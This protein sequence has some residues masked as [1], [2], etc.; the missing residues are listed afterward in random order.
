MVP[1]VWQMCSDGL[2][3]SLVD[4]IKNLETPYHSFSLVLYG[5]Y[6]SYVI[7]GNSSQDECQ[8]DGTEGCQPCVLMIIH[9]CRMWVARD[10]LRGAKL[11]TTAN[12]PRM[13][14]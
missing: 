5:F 13:E 2:T 8:V 4:V 3:L 14:L 11:L 10:G 7:N 1:V 6:H 9:G 12:Q